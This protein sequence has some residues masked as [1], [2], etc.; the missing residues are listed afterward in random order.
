MSGG[1]SA[2]KNS[3]MKS[4]DSCLRLETNGDQTNLDEWEK[5]QGH[6]Q[7]NGKPQPEPID[8]PPEPE[9]KP[10]KKQKKTA[11]LNVSKRRFGKVA[12]ATF[13]FEPPSSNC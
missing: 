1:I 8:E 3:I 10:S 5:K 9:H 13:R 4:Y 11:L 6:G 12:N 2:I 7:A